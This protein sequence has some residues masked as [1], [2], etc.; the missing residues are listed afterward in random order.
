MAIKV[1]KQ[2]YIEQDQNTILKRLS[3][4]RGMPEAEIIREAITQHVQGLRVRRRDLR[5]WAAEREFIAQLIA[6][7]SAGE[8]RTWRREDLHER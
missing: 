2:I 4:E 7:G 8:Q 5:A 3:D 1:R 6:Q